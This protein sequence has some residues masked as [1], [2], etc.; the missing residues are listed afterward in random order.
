MSQAER[1]YKI[2]R[3]LRRQRAV[4]IRQFL[5]E[6]EVSRATFRRDYDVLRDR[7]GAQVEY[8]AT[9]R[10]YRL[11]NPA[12]QNSRHELPGLWFDSNELH[13]LLTFHYFLE[14]LQPGLLS[15]QIAPLKVRIETLLGGQ[16][17]VLNEITRRVRLIARSSR[18]LEP[19]SFAPVARAVLAR[20]RLHFEYHG[21]G[22]DEVTERHISPQRLVHYRENWYLDGWDHRK[23]ALRTFA[24]ERIARPHVL[25][26][27]ARDIPEQRLNRHFTES[28]GIF[29][30]RPRRRALLRFAPGCARWVADEIWH[31]RQK[32]R[33]EDGYYLLEIPYSDDRELVLDILKYGADVEVLGPKSLRHR[34]L[35]QLLRAA[36]QYRR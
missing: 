3:L 21:R 27:R 22:K 6:L 32:G 26:E 19:A 1:L 14:A 4:P 17:G 5:E 2:E 25:E 35:D 8:D 28:Y 20:R 15:E 16:D 13:A 23:R 24:V 31:P 36:S 34:V 10:G 29:A 9:L 33:Y 7:M 18:H 30:G 11:S 12:A